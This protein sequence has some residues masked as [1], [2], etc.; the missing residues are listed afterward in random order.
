MKTEIES[1]VCP[2]VINLGKFFCFLFGKE[3]EKVQYNDEKI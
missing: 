1:Y 3:K 2:K